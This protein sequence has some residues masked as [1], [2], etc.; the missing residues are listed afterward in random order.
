MEASRKSISAVSMLIFLTGFMAAGK[1]RIGRELASLLGHD[2][3]D[4]DDQIEES[5]GVTIA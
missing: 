1:S 4:L 3:V 5:T 2:F